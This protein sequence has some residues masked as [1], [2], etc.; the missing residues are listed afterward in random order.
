MAKTTKKEVNTEIA[1]KAT[2]AMTI[3]TEILGIVGQIIENGGECDDNTLAMLQNWQAALEVKAGNIGL[4]KARLESD[5][6]YYKVIEE[7]AR[8]R[9][10]TTENTI[11]RLK[12]YLRD[13]MKTADMKSIKGDLF[14]FSLVDGR[15][16]TVV[17]NKSALPFDYV[18]I[19]EV[20]TPQTDKIKEALEAGKEVPGAHLERGEDYVMIRAAASKGE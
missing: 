6:E 15:V 14:S 17:E 7:S 12:N 4:V 16:K 2:S 5:I 8:A 18:N 9:R 13:C 19:V 3:A 1:V 20:V 10:K 11:E